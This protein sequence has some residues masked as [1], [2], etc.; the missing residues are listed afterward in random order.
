[1]ETKVCSRCKQE[2]PLSEFN[3][4][5]KWYQPFCKKCQHKYQK[6]W[7]QKNKERHKVN[8]RKRKQELK[9]W[10]RNY[11]ETLSCSE[12]GESRGPCLVF[13]HK[14]SAEKESE[15]GDMVSNNYSKES[16]LEEISKCIVLCANCHLVLHWEEQH[17][18]L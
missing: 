14:D 6:D 3:K 9:E 1:M 10:F 5:G 8:V 17:S 4:K 18:D 13:H 7:Y 2:K 12:C 11:K 15:I 16:I